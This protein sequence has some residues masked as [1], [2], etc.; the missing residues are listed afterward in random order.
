MQTPSERFLAPSLVSIG[1]HCE[2]QG[3]QCNESLPKSENAVDDCIAVCRGGGV[4]TSDEQRIKALRRR[5][6][7][8]AQNYLSE[9]SRGDKFLSPAQ[10]INALHELRV[11]QIELEMQN[12]ELRSTQ[13]QLN[14]ER[15]R[16][17]K[18]YDMAPVSYLSVSQKGLLLQANLSAAQLL[19]EPR[20]QLQKQLFS[21]FIAASDQDTYYLLRRK[22][23]DT[24]Q[25]QTCDLQMKPTG[26]QPFFAR[27]TVNLEQDDDGDAAVEF[28]IVISDISERR[29]AEQRLVESEFRWK[30]A[31]EGSGDGLWDWNV[32]QS[33]VFFSPRWKEMLG[34]S[35][36][37]IGSGLDE[38]SKRIHPDDLARVMV[39]VQAHL[40]GTT[41]QYT[42]EHR[43]S[44]KDGSYKW[45][46][47]RGLVV[48]RDTAC[49]PV[50]VIGTHSDIS[51]R[52]IM[53]E[54]V[55]QLAFHDPLTNL[56]NRRLLA[57]RLMQAMGA[58]KR[59]G[60]YGAVLF[61]DLDNFK[62]LNDAHGHDFGD[63]LLIEVAERL[64]ACVREA[65]TVARF[66]G[67][68]FVVMIGEL[69]ADKDGSRA[70]AMSVAE[71]I[72][73][74]LSQPYQLNIKHDGVVDTAVTHYCTASI[75]VALFINH[76][77]SSD[78]VLKWADAAMYR[79]KDA[80][81]NV[82]RFHE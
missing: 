1:D 28:H 69:L 33:T 7:A 51:D 72:R 63:L 3:G 79:A 5:A 23:I 14:A 62:P 81:R 22:V 77:A 80:G 32:P 40:D 10:A 6:E 48:E 26:S 60:C 52:K 34:F 31:I 71:K 27:L 53:E 36:D 75:G 35:R 37:E 49:K 12:E 20:R 76:E 57:D 66:G 78:D 24:R 29:L 50:R 30:F 58:N 8:L 19:G 54:K 82:I 41:P 70:Q 18:L 55:R 67:D 4:A 73:S 2:N 43:V 15:E 74:T 68:E 65:D 25:T 42:N 46:L 11:H 44:C 38:W 39:D 13:L 45:I 16:Y 47:D 61:L 21:N 59:S 9:E 56:P 64:K 17:F